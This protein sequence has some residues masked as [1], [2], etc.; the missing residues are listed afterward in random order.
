M[1]LN[2][3]FTNTSSYSFNTYI[4]MIGWKFARAYI[5]QD[6]RIKRTIYDILYERLNWCRSFTFKAFIMTDYMMII[7]QSL[8]GKFMWIWWSISF[9]NIMI[10]T[11]MIFEFSTLCAI[12]VRLIDENK[13]TEKLIWVYASY[14]DKN[15][16]HCSIVIY[17]LRHIYFSTLLKINYNQTKL[18]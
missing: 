16:L 2:S 8:Q 10:I 3:I 12:I 5:Y 6:E 4:C 15:V 11:I 9:S 13:L 17:L 18:K 7:C 14:G 1:V